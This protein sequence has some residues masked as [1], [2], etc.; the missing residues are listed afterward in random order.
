MED[1]TPQTIE[2]ALGGDR[3]SLDR[4]VHTLTPAIQAEVARALVR[5]GA[6]RGRDGRQEVLDATQEIFCALFANDGKALRAW[7]PEKGRK[8]VSFVRLI[9]KRKVISMLRSHTKS[10]WS[11]DPTE[12][13]TLDVIAAGERDTLDHEE[14]DA[15]STLWARLKPHLGER[16]VLLFQLLFVE[17]QEVEHVMERTQMSR[18]AIY[19]WRSRFRK[20]ARNIGQEMGLR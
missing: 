14:R 9:A 20:Q 2:R 6:A 1:I 15:V 11:D 12:S 7:D 13:E 5:G 19:A 10:P 3:P 16:G 18:D 17:E 8:L 4:L